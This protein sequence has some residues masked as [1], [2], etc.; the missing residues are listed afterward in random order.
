MDTVLSEF[1]FPVTEKLS[2]KELS[3]VVVDA[4]DY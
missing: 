1:S 2:D 4:R 3:A